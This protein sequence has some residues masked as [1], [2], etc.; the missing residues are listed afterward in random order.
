[1]ILKRAYLILTISLL[2]QPQQSNAVDSQTVASVGGIMVV[3]GMVWIA[4][5]AIN[6]QC[7]DKA[8]EITLRHGVGLEPEGKAYLF[9]DLKESCPNLH[10]GI[11]TK[12]F[13]KKDYEA[14]AD[15]LSKRYSYCHLITS[16]IPQGARDAF[17]SY[18]N[19]H[20]AQIVTCDQQGKLYDAHLCDG[21]KQ[22]LEVIKSKTDNQA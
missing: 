22:M 21:Y 11:L 8:F 17:R 19:M 7:K 15:D 14:L 6:N 20:G 4:F 13:T 1:M 12:S 2:M 18:N 16:E 9:I 3:G 5:K 10:L